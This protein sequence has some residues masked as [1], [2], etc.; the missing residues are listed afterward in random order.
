MLRLAGDRALRRRLGESGRLKVQASFNWSTK[1][2]E[3]LEIY[4]RTAAGN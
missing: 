2:S 4:E 3:M 1:I